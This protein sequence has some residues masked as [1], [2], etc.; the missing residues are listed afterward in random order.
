MKVPQDLWG[1]YGKKSIRTSL[2]KDTPQAKAKSEVIRLTA[3]YDAEFDA[4]RLSLRPAK[5]TPLAAAMIP[6]ISKALEGHIL[7]ADEEI[8]AEGLD[9]AEFDRWEAETAATAAE[10]SRAYARGDSSPI[11]AALA[12]WLNGLGIEAASESTEFKTLR[13][14]FLK[15]RLK[16]LQG[17]LARNRGELVET[18]QGPSL[19]DLRAGMEPGPS[20]STPKAAAKG[21][22]RL[23]SVIAYW[24][25]D[26]SKSH[27]TTATADTMVKEFTKLHGD[28]PLAEITKA[29]FVALRD[30]QLTRVKPAT[31]QARFNLLKAAFTVCLEDDQLGIEENPLQYVKIR[32]QEAEEKERDAFTA[33][34]LQALFDSSVFTAGDRPIGGRGEAAFWGPLIALY[35]G[36]RLDEILSLRTDGLYV[37]DGV[38]VFHF[39]HRP[40]LGQKLKGRAKNV[41]RVP[42]HPELIRLGILEYLKEVSKLPALP[43]GAGWLFPGIDRSEKVRNHSS[44]W[45]AWFGRYLTRCGIK[46]DKLVFHSFRHTFKHFSRASGIPE[47]HHDAMTGHTTA[48]VARRY[49]SCA[50]YPVEV[51]AGSIPKLTFGKLD[52]SRVSQPIASCAD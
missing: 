19:D 29:H 49:G 32:N 39:R 13:R 25:R 37:T 47:D 5:A 16:A 20:P 15:A 22:P 38:P 31:V 1:H 30:Q 24:K 27:R 8:R 12:D 10:I 44:A 26:G 23:S 51:L 45:G 11:D 42:V 6:A 35:T 41:R 40:E 46:S 34:Q 43:D 4:V 17:K 9:E 21:A 2:G 14:E 52:L 7:A 28:L 33:D 3:Q 18:P 48:E 50:G 36:A